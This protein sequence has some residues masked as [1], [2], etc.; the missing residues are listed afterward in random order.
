MEDKYTI[1]LSESELK[2]LAYALWDKKHWYWQLMVFIPI[3]VF[4]PPTLIIDTLA[5]N[6]IFMTITVLG[7]LFAFFMVMH[8]RDVYMKMYTN[9]VMEANHE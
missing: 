6:I 8:I 7:V 9:Q 4:V 2:T 3:A 1:E 5:T